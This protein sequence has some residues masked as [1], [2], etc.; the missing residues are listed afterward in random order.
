MPV[1]ALAFLYSLKCCSLKK[2][3]NYE[4]PK[5]EVL[6]FNYLVH[7]GEE[8]PLYFIALAATSASSCVFVVK[9]TVCGLCESILNAQKA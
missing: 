3:L 7:N 8:S 1:L 9:E 4:G 2:G 5:T 6:L